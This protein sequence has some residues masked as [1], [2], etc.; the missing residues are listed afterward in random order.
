MIDYEA[1]AMLIRK[2]R[3]PRHQCYPGPCDK[4]MGYAHRY[5]DAALMGNNGVYVLGKIPTCGD[6]AW[7]CREGSHNDDCYE[8]VRVHLCEPSV[9]N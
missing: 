3:G 7:K 1:V 5:V 4:C 8:L 2:D 9:P 6:K